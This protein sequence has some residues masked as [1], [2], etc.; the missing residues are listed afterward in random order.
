MFEGFVG[1]KI[2]PLVPDKFVVGSQ[3]REINGVTTEQGRRFFLQLVNLLQGSFG[4][5][6]EGDSDYSNLLAGT[7][8]KIEGMFPG[9]SFETS[10]QKARY[11]DYLDTASR[12]RTWAEA[13]QVDFDLDGAVDAGRTI[14]DGVPYDIY[15]N[16]T[17]TFSN[18]D[19]RDSVDFSDFW[20]S[21]R[22]GLP[23]DRSYGEIIGSGDYHDL[24]TEAGWNLFTS[25]LQFKRNYIYGMNTL[26]MDVNEP[27]RE[28]A[29]DR[30]NE[31]VNSWRI[32]G[33]GNYNDGLLWQYLNM[34]PDI[35]GRLGK[36]MGAEGSTGTGG[37]FYDWV[38]NDVLPGYK[39]IFHDRIRAV[40]IHQDRVHADTSR[41]QLAELRSYLDPAT[42]RLIIDEEHPE[43]MARAV[44]LISG[45]RDSLNSISSAQRT[46][47]REMS[48]V[49]GEL[50]LKVAE[51]AQGLG[52]LSWP[53]A[54]DET[55]DFGGIL[56]GIDDLLIAGNEI[57]RLQ[58]GVFDHP[59]T[60]I[61]NLFKEYSVESRYSSPSISQLKFENMGDELKAAV[62]K[63][64]DTLN[65]K[66]LGH[67]VGITAINM[68]N[69]ANNK[70]ID[71]K[72]REK[73]T[74]KFLEQVAQSRAEQKRETAQ[75]AEL[76]AANKPKPKEKENVSKVNKKGGRVQ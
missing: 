7:Q 22:A 62:R 11:V 23:D 27:N 42:S 15:L 48:I 28:G 47:N 73:Q 13:G 16:Q 67:A 34:R 54:I 26:G 43:R 37:G 49:P 61:D 20:K 33:S 29:I 56:T 39:R 75:K 69:Q 50:T 70:R 24:D 17:S 71:T 76:A 30:F 59:N 68:F 55:T 40:D 63:T 12:R 5:T 36:L 35:T 32:R 45:L 52:G 21:V 31:V 1:I 72:L 60:V 2:P 64:F 74:E 18:N 19:G 38:K 58:T 51:F 6:Y 46:I 66:P 10:P 8:H 9:L 57:D 4:F 3:S 44:E 65:Q 14:E 53:S 25:I 41:A